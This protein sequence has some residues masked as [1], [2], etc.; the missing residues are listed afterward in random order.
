MTKFKVGDRVVKDGKHGTIGFTTTS[1][2]CVQWDGAEYEGSIPYEKLSSEGNMDKYTELKNRIEALKDGW[3]KEADDILQEMN[4][5][6]ANFYFIAI[7]IRNDHPVNGCVRIIDANTEVVS[8]FEFRG[9]CEKLKAFKQALLWLLDHSDIK[10]DEK[11]EKIAKLEADL[12]RIQEEIKELK[13]DA[14]VER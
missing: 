3:N 1:L 14:G 11:Q 13:E 8:D 7:E 12:A 10:K 9:Q 4:L 5:P 6:T 2:C